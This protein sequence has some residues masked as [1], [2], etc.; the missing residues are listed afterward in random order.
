MKEKHNISTT[1]ENIRIINKTH[2]IADTHKI[3]LNNCMI[4]VTL[5]NL[6]SHQTNVP[7]YYKTLLKK[8][9]F[10]EKYNI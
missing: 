3:Y 4:S 2:Y 6:L 8:C 7:D 1:E 10:L 5:L 9:T